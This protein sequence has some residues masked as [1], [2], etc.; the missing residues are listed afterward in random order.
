MQPGKQ[1]RIDSLAALRRLYPWLI[2]LWIASILL[3]FFIIRVLGSGMGQRV[4]SVLGLR[5]PQ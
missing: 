3:V 5:H 2:E 4:L 1:H